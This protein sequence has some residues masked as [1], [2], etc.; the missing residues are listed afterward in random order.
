M[1]TRPLGF[2]SF[3]I[4]RIPIRPSLSFIAART[5]TVAGNLNSVSRKNESDYFFGEIPKVSRVFFPFPEAPGQTVGCPNFHFDGSDVPRQHFQKG[6]HI[7][8]TARL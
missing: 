8:I 3:S 2:P 4:F 7:I 1:D 5:S 6:Q